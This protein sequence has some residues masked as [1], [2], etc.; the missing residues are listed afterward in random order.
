MEGGRWMVGVE[1]EGVEG[2]GRKWRV[3]GGESADV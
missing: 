3:D 1:G 2:G